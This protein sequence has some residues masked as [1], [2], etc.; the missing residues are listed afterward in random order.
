M[1]TATFAPGK[2]AEFQVIQPRTTYT[3][4][5]IPS[6][7]KGLPKLTISLCPECTGK[8]EAV[9]FEEDGKVIMEKTCPEHG[10]F[11]DVIYSDV[12]L[13]LKMEEWTFGDGRGIENPAVPEATN[14]PDQCGLCSMHTSH[15]VLANVDLTN[16]CNLTCP[17]CFANANAAGYLYEPTFDEVRK[18]LQTLRDQRPVS[19]RVVQFSGGEPTIY[20]RFVDVLKMAKEMGFTQLQAA[21]NGLKFTDPEFAQQCGEAGLHTLYLQFDGVCDDI[22][23]RTRGESLFEMKLKCIDNVR[24]AGMKICFVPT[25]VKGIN[26]HQI[27]DIVRLAIDNIDVVSAI[28]FQPVSFCGRISKA[29]LEE[30]RFTQSDFAHAVREQTGLADPYN[31]WFPLSCVS[32]F[33]KLIAA[34]RG[35]T[36]PTLTPHPHCS[37]GTYMFVDKNKHAT[38]ITRFVD[39]GAML[40]DIDMLARRAE[41]RRI[42]FWSKI[43]AWNSLRKH[44]HE[45]R[46]PE[47]LTFQRF[48]QTLQGLVDKK[49]GR[50]EMEKQEF[51]YKTLM[52]ASMHFMDVY[53]YDVE[54]VRRCVI[55]YAAPNGQLYPFCAYNA[56]P[57]FREK[58]EKAYSMSFEQQP[59]MQELI[60]IG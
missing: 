35:E 59:R 22:Y 29:E 10:L 42:K 15:T 30:K 21:T 53:N 4:S 48:L 7:P 39:I 49:Y 45:D 16:R 31:D 5:A 14:C 23:K 18:M 32:P 34:L 46:A 1:S 40:Q 17:V 58:I 19:G 36:V 54:R 24:K 52:V 60:N 37:M 8:I 3:G 2:A 28:S 26:D 9:L 25:I 55:H 57:T 27:G 13:Y 47:G 20:P 41:Q 50:G 43:S 44:Y 6:V 12:K 11:R 33:S 56:G 38:P 51:S